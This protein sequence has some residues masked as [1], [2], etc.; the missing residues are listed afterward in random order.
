M[1]AAKLA[2]LIRKELL[3]THVQMM[4]LLAML[5]LRRLLTAKPSNLLLQKELQ[6]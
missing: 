3:E 2:M 6:V 4:F 5:K 1:M